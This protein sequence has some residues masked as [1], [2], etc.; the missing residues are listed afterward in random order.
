MEML[1]RMKQP[2]TKNRESK[3]PKNNM[4]RNTNSDNVTKNYFPIIQTI[5]N[6]KTWTAVMKQSRFWLQ[7]PSPMVGTPSPSFDY[8]SVTVL[9]REQFFM[10]VGCWGFFEI[11]S[12]F[13]IALMSLKST[14]STWK[15]LPNQKIV[16]LVKNLNSISLTFF[17]FKKKAKMKLFLKSSLWL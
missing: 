8:K 2:P 7:T 14:F 5:S 4:D 16:R 15:A 13:G 3:I 17:C 11:E 1:I 6:S 10:L 12:L 9:T